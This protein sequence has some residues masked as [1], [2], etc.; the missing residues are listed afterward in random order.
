MLSHVVFLHGLCP[1]TLY[2]I[3]GPLWSLSLIFQLY[4]IFPL[5]FTAM[6][7]WTTAPSRRACSPSG[8]RSG[9]CWSSSRKSR[10]FSP[11]VFWGFLPYRLPPFAL[12]MAVAYWAG[13]PASPGSGA[14]RRS[15]WGE[16]AVL[17]GGSVVARTGRDYPDVGFTA[18]LLA[19]PTPARRG[20]L[21]GRL[22][23][24]PALAGLGTISYGLYLTHDLVL[25]R[26]CAA[27]RHFV[28]EPGLL[29]DASLV[30]VGLGLSLGVAW[31]LYRLI[32]KRPVGVDP[33]RV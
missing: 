8:W 3:S 29:S 27:Y 16:A 22:L 28:P 7:R 4:L 12:G 31:A 10:G 26:L 18:L 19:A 14:R 6:E 23:S 2:G 21:L 5:L 30:A 17:L 1:D 33:V 24:R 11:E 9:S 32:E 15:R 25:S 13:H 20:G